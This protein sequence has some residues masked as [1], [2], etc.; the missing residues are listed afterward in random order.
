M[1]RIDPI[2]D[3]DESEAETRTVH[4]RLGGVS[5]FLSWSCHEWGLLISITASEAGDAE[6]VRMIYRFDRDRPD[7]VAVT[8]WAQGRA[9]SVPR[10]LQ[11]SFTTRA[12]S[13]SRLVVRLVHAGGES[14][15]FFDLTGSNRALGLLACV[16]D[17]DPGTPRPTAR[18]EPPPLPF[19]PDPLTV[20]EYEISAVEEPPRLINRDEVARELGRS[21]PA[22]E[23]RAGTGGEVTLRLRVLASGVVDPESI[24]VVASTNPVFDQPARTVAAM[25]RFTPARVNGRPVVV[26]V[27]QPLQFSVPP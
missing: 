24:T 22:E 7:T 26:W 8:T 25:V 18:K 13:A 17:L 11:H 12:R 16:R 3:R 20:H 5:S 23:R 14:D 9:L 15:R 2:S 1:P 6:R 4:D 19:L 27:T 10:E 21:Y